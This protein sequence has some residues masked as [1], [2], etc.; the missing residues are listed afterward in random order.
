MDHCIYFAGGNQEFGKLR[1]ISNQTL[2]LPSASTIPPPPEDGSSL[3]ITFIHYEGFGLEDIHVTSRSNNDEWT[4][5][6]N[7]GPLVNPDQAD[8]CPA[9]SSYF[10]SFFFDSERAG[11]FGNKDLWYIP[12]SSIE[13]IR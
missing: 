5:L 9:F 4:Q 2:I 10:E 1:R 12:Y 7:L 11:G 13:D 6:V 8:R 3:Y